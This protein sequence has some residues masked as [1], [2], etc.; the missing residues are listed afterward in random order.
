MSVNYHEGRLQLRQ[1]KKWVDLL[2]LVE[3]ETGPIYLYDLQV[4]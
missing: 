2:E 4:I 3:G 1:G